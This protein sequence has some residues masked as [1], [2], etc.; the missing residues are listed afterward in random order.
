MNSARRLQIKKI[1]SELAKIKT[2]IDSVAENIATIK[3]DEEDY[4]DDIPENLQGSDRYYKADE[5]CDNIES[6][7]NDLDSIKEELESALDSL[8]E[9]MA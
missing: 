7:I 5:A 9:A 3:A 2:N 1:I 4:R 8:E 6:A